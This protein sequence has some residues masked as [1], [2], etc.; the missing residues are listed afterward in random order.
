MSQIMHSPTGQGTNEGHRW[1]DDQDE[2]N[3]W[4]Y[5]MGETTRTAGTKNDSIYL[6]RKISHMSTAKTHMTSLKVNA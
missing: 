3:G 1:L 5:E 2:S 6:E 4:L